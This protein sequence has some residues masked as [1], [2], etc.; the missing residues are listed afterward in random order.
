[1][2]LSKEMSFLTTSSAQFNYQFCLTVCMAKINSST[3]TSRSHV[4]MQTNARSR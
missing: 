1:M 4:S 2:Q 3:I